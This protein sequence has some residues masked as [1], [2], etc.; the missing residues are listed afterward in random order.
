MRRNV[1]FECTYPIPDDSADKW[2]ATTMYKRFSYDVYLAWVDYLF[3]RYERPSLFQ[4][5]QVRSKY[6]ELAGDRA[7]NWV[8]IHQPSLSVT[9]WK[10]VRGGTTI[11][12]E[13]D[14]VQEVEDA[15]EVSI[16][17]LDRP[18]SH[19]NRPRVASLY[20]LSNDAFP[21]RW[22]KAMRSEKDEEDDQATQAS[23]RKEI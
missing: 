11:S 2:C 4:R 15:Y 23:M 8:K 6:P 12:K 18:L 17:P 5:A 1:K 16:Q 9:F 7:L 21:P 22:T 20:K 14:Y 3:V 13:Q 19:S 10:L